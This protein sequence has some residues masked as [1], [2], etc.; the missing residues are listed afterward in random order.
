MWLGPPYM[1]RK[2]TL[3]ALGWNMGRFGASGL[4][5]L[6]TPSAATASRA[7]KPSADS[8]P[9]RATEVKPPPASH[10]N[11]RRVRPQNWR[12]GGSELRVSL[13]GFSF[14]VNGSSSDL[15]QVN[16]LVRVQRQQAI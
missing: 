13:M 9:V 3:F 14:P 5:N 16:K 7:K 2:M 1:N 4:T 6:L 12:C 10:K 11:S 15:I 8:R